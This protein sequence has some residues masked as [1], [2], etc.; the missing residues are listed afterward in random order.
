MK[1]KIWQPH[2]CQMSGGSLFWQM[3][4]SHIRQMYSNKTVIENKIKIEKM[5]KKKKTSQVPRSAKAKLALKNCDSVIETAYSTI[6]LAKILSAAA[7]GLY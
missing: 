5:A 6:G 2:I 7:L 3:S 4:G 1:T